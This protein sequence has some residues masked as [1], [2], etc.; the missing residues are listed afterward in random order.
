MFQSE[1]TINIEDFILRYYHDFRHL[2]F[3]DHRKEIK[4]SLLVD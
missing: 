4:S 2:S 3:R 1:I